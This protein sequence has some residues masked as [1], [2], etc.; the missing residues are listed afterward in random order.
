VAALTDLLSRQS[1]GQT[2]NT[3]IIPG[4][5][6][7]DV[8]RQ[9]SSLGEDYKHWFRAKFLQQFRLFFCYQ[10]S[11]DAKII[12]LAWINDDSSLLAYRRRKP[13]RR[14][15]KP[16]RPRRP[17][18]CTCLCVWQPSTEQSSTEGTF[19]Q[20]L[21]ASSTSTSPWHASGAHQQMRSR[22]R[23]SSSAFMSAGCATIQARY[24]AMTSVREPSRPTTNGLPHLLGR[25]M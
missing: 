21:F 7:R 4:D 11:V 14:S 20:R 22:P 13:I 25:P 24:F 19:D 23:S 2:T 3:K 15:P 1:I 17:S 5:P 6:T 8:Y 18:F 16:S 9:G 10:Q 12:V